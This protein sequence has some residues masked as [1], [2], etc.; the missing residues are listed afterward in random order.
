[1]GGVNVRHQKIE[2]DCIRYLLCVVALAGT[3]C[4]SEPPRSLGSTN[5]QIGTAPA[6]GEVDL[7]A[8]DGQWIRPAKDYASTRFSTLTEI[9]ASNV[10]NLRAIGTFSTGALRG[11]E[12]APIVVGGT[13][14]I[15][16]P[17]PN[18]VYALD[19]TKPGF[20]AK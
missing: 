13:M 12:S 15:I 3:A 8:D 14:Y 5:V 17:F 7:P 20:P 4:R 1:M 6:N 2:G 19:L 9:N 18:I 10:K 16:T 11:H